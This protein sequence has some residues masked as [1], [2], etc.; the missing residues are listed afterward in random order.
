VKLITRILSEEI[1]TLKQTPIA[2]RFISDNSWT[3]VE[4][5]SSHWKTTPQTS[6]AVHIAHEIPVTNWYAVLSNH[7][8]SQKTSDWSSQSN[9]EQLAGYYRKKVKGPQRK[10]TL[11]E[12]Q[13]SWPMNHQLQEPLLQESVKNEDWISRIP[14]IVNGVTNN[15]YKAEF[16]S[17]Y[18]YNDEIGVIESKLTEII[19]ACKKNA[20]SKRHKMIFMGGS[21]IRDYVGD[22]KSLLNNNFELYSIVKPGSSTNELKETAKKEISQLS[23][24]DLIVILVVLMI[25]K[26]M[27][28]P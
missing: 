2:D 13:P 9:F 5:R 19:T 7:H 14:T 3:A 4:S 28:F 1:K 8:E 21:H 22:L 23:Q 24:D 20:A 6:R 27:N 26:S 16:T 11:R 12:T 17:N 10:E 25:M 15:N 18:E